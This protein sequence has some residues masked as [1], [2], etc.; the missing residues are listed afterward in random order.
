[1]CGPIAFSLGINANNKFGFTTKNLTY[2]FGRVLTYTTLG[3]ILG[4]IGFGVSFA[5]MQQPLSIGIGILMILMAFLPKILAIQ[6][7]ATNLLQNI[8]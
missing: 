8:C 5:G 4:V 7:L 2:Q 3:A 6:I 1:M